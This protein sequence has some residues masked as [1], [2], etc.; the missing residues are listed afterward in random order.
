M[1]TKELS[2]LLKKCLYENK[3]YTDALDIE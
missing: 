2:K 1:N 3:A